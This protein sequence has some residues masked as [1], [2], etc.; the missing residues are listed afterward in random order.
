MIVVGNRIGEYFL[1]CRE[2]K[3]NVEFRPKK[4]KQHSVTV[5]LLSRAVC[6]VPFL[7]SFGIYTLGTQWYPISKKLYISITGIS[8]FFWI[9]PLFLSLVIVLHTYLGIK[10][11]RDGE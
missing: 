2:P 7:P 5:Y 9:F 4:E 3:I 11:E 8:T 10:E 1:S 6:A